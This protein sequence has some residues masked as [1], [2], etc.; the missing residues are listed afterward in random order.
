ML[1]LFFPILV[2]IAAF[3]SHRD[4]VLSS[5]SSSSS[6]WRGGEGIEG[7]LEGVGLEWEGEEGDRDEEE[8]RNPSGEEG[9]GEKI[10]IVS[11]DE[12]LAAMPDTRSVST[13]H[14]FVFNTD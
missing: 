12:L 14:G 13:D 1:F 8:T 7:G 2:L 3:E 5:K 6:N 10:S 11:F 9:E 4:R